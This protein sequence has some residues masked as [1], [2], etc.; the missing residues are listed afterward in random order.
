[1]E[2]SSDDDAPVGSSGG[3]TPNKN[4]GGV[5]YCCCG[6]GEPALP[7]YR[8]KLPGGSPGN[9][10]LAR[11]WIRSIKKGIK[12][13]DLEGIVTKRNQLLTSKHWLEDRDPRL[14]SSPPV[15]NRGR[16]KVGGEFTVQG[17]VP[18]IGPAEW[19]DEEAAPS[20][21]DK[22][23]ARAHQTTINEI[24]RWLDSIDTEV[25][26]HRSRGEARDLKRVLQ[27]A[28][29][30]MVALSEEKE[31]AERELAEL[32]ERTKRATVELQEALA[33]N[34]GLQADLQELVGRMGDAIA[35]EQRAHEEEAA[36][37]KEQLSDAL[38][39]S[40]QSLTFE[41]L[42][43]EGGDEHMKKRVSNLAFFPDYE[44][45]VAFFECLECDGMLDSVQLRRS[46]ADDADDRQE[47][48]A[49]PGA[50]ALAGR[51]SIFFVLFVLRT[52]I[53]VADASPL[54]GIDESTG[55]M[56][57]SSYL[58]FL[59]EW[60]SSEFPTPTKEQVIQATPEEFKN[61]IKGWDLQLIFDATEFRTEFPSDLVVYRTLWSAYKHWTTVKFLG[62]IYPTPGGFCAKTADPTGFGGS[63][64]DVP[65]TLASPI[66][67][68]LHDRMASLADKGFTL[69]V[70]FAK[71][72]HYLL[73][74]M[75]A[76]NKQKAFTAEDAD[77]SHAIGH[78]RIYIEEAFRR[79]RE[80]KIFRKQVKMSQL[81]LIG[82][83]YS[84]CALLT[85]YQTLL[86]KDEADPEITI[87]ERLWGF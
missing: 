18:T 63:A 68:L 65:C 57:F 1:M 60:L 22:P 52:G 8:H 26:L 83:T 47:K 31:E 70:Q 41:M 10:D 16:R 29:N 27:R 34:D 38:A 81:D 56:Y 21:A 69:H 85:N 71:K 54:F 11:V 9:T 17:A 7:G 14:G 76:Y 4:N 59:H 86:K 46:A 45:L 73:I 51:D 43:P 55:S 66:M 36:L 5:H 15:G 58:L 37:L 35:E 32:T 12:P 3:A 64:G 25:E 49:R 24:C 13:S 74:P 44:C 80:F 78:L 77:L 84:V 50:R 33:D 62:S 23:A 53:D 61:K 72:G 40:K 87:A 39:K 75:Y 42:H 30:H 20:P 82:K 6:C 2:D 79:V 28:V 48:K 67:G 19:E